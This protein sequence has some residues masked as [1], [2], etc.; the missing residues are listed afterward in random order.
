MGVSP[1]Q[2]MKAK[3]RL[4]PKSKTYWQD[5]GLVTGEVMDGK[6]FQARQTHPTSDKIP[7]NGTKP[8]DV[9][10]AKFAQE[11]YTIAP[12]YSK[13]AY[14]VISKNDVKTMGKKV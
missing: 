4:F 8:V 7:A 13:G 6:D 14:Q 2:L 12:A 3:K 11:N 1:T 5:H 10:K 9:S